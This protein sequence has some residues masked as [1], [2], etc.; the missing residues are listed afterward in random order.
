VPWGLPPAAWGLLAAVGL[1]GLVACSA[2]HGALIL[3][4]QRPG[5][6]GVSALLVVVL[7]LGPVPGVPVSKAGGGGEASFYWQLTDRLGTG[8]VMLDETGARQVHRT[9]SPFG[10][11]HAS[12]GTASWLPRHFA[13]HR[14]DEDSGL[15]YMQARWMDPKSGTFLSVDP[16]VADS[17]DPQ[18]FNAYAYARNNPITHVDPEGLRPIYAPEL[19]YPAERDSDDPRMPPAVAL[20]DELQSWLP[21]HIQQGIQVRAQRVEQLKNE[22]FYLKVAVAAAEEFD[23]L[24]LVAGNAKELILKIV[25]SLFL[26]SGQKELIDEIRDK[27][28]E[29]RALGE[30]PENAWFD[31]KGDRI[32]PSQDKKEQRKE[33]EIRIETPDT[34]STPSAPGTFLTGGGSPPIPIP[35]PQTYYVPWT[36]PFGF[37]DCLPAFWDWF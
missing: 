35:T 25:L 21:R 34:A 22:L 33:L 13:G 37:C 24:P 18:S 1:L 2:Q 31:E 17:G 12:V 6:A 5:Y 29:L 16:V 19:A 14:K 20:I 32:I 8:M 36:D 30:T 7:V 23:G 26:G 3:V 4:L 27:E 11:E 28:L 10:V 9:Y 15:L